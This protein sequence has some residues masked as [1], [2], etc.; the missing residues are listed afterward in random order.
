M[1]ASIHTWSD[2]DG[3][4]SALLDDG[5]LVTWAPEVFDASSLRHLRVGQRV[6]VDLDGTTVTRLWIVGIGEGETIR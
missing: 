6:S 1:Q 3:S 4:G 2:D 5:R